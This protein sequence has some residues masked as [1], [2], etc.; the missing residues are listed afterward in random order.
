MS[1]QPILYKMENNNNGGFT[2]TFFNK[3]KEQSF[4]IILLVGIL[5]YQNNT[6]KTN[7]S[8]YEDMI[9]DKDA[10]ILK[11]TND[12][13]QRLIDRI[14]YLQDQRD[15]YVEELIETK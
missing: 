11:Q 3:L 13:R 5:W 8:E 15:K 12:E 4:T 10:I 7:L 14:S 9:K 1:L 6:Y 2:D